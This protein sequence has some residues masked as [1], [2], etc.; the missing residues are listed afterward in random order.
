MIENIKQRKFLSLNDNINL[1]KTLHQQKHLWL[2]DFSLTIL[3]KR[4][5]FHHKFQCHHINIKHQKV[6]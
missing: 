1:R 2:K 3:V 5:Y 6:L 4:L